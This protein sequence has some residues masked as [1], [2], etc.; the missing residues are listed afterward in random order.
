MKTPFYLIN[1]FTNSS[2]KCGGNPCAV[3]QLKERI[4]ENRMQRIAHNLNYPATSFI[5]ENTNGEFEVAWYAPDAEISLC[6][7]GAYAS[8]AFLYANNPPSNSLT[9]KTNDGT[10]I[11]GMLN[12][13]NIFMRMQNIDHEESSEIPKGLSEALGSNILNY[14]KTDNK[15][16]VLLQ[17]QNAVSVMKPNFEAL[18]HIDIFGYSVTAAGDG[19]V[20]DFVSRTIIPYVQQLEDH[21]TGS[22]HAALFP[23]WKNILN[24]S[25]LKALQLSPNG[26]YFE[27]CV[28]NEYT[29]MNSG[30]KIQSKGSLDL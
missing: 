27:G 8:F 15:H 4:D 30:V 29:T 21:A 13:G 5:Y 12:N 14:Y 20:I 26:G 24:K 23:Y 6:G 22:S 9:L 19:S 1:A 7:H 2:Y 10:T 25:T 17:D 16:I 11:D 28:E 3:I 18:R